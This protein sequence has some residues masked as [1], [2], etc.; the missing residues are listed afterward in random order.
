V[1]PPRLFF[2][3]LITEAFRLVTG[4]LRALFDIALV[5]TMISVALTLVGR[6]MSGERMEPL[7]AM[8]V[9]LV[10]FV[11]TAMF[12]VAWHRLVLLGPGAVA[13]TPGLGWTAR[14]R[15][16]L[17]QFL[18]ISAIPI[19]LHALFWILLPWPVELSG[20]GA[21]PPGVE[22]AMPVGLG[23]TITVII[24]LRLSFGLAAP[25]VDVA[26]T[27]HLSWRYGKGNGPTILFA[28]LLMI[29]LGTIVKMMATAFLLAMAVA[30]FGAPLSLGPWLVVTLIAETVAYV[31]IAPMVTVQALIF[32]AL[33]GWAP[34][35]PLRQP[36][37]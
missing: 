12:A 11:P 5:P 17:G 30:M 25:S 18:L 8:A 6:W 22:S 28:I 31:S 19:I 27:P 34:G 35:G 4:N 29:A 1:Q 21:L 9:K 7:E 24:A 16:Y 36:P 32:R 10:D 15:G 26:W 37:P 3:D 2:S 23:F 13:G 20:T 33:T 14:E